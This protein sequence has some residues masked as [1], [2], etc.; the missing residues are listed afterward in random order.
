MSL[1]NLKGDRFSPVFLT[2]TLTPSFNSIWG[3]CCHLNMWSLDVP[4]TILLRIFCRSKEAP[5]TQIMREDFCDIWDLGLEDEKANSL[6]YSAENWFNIFWKP[7][8]FL[9]VLIFLNLKMINMI[10]YAVELVS[11]H[12]CRYSKSLNQKFLE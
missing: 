5:Y 1:N 8:L 9:E 6:I 4:K 2:L 10:L 3:Y 11:F 12:C 7:C